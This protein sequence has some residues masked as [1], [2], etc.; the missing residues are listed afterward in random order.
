MERAG[1]EEFPA[2]LPW[3][4]PAVGEG[5]KGSGPGAAAIRAAPGGSRSRA[6]MVL[7][8]RQAPP[9]SPPGQSVARCARPRPAAVAEEPPPSGLRRPPARRLQRPVRP[10]LMEQPTARMAGPAAQEPSVQRQWRS[11]LSPLERPRGAESPLTI[12]APSQLVAVERPE[13]QN[14]LPLVHRQ[15]H[16][17]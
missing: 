14:A 4:K 1:D 7:L 3:G 13:A 9:A 6:A 16:P 10:P 12:G 15:C 8:V 2:L 17:R 5:P 11:E